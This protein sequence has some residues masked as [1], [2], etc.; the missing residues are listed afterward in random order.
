MLG[1]PRRFQI[2][3]VLISVAT[4]SCGGGGGGGGG[5]QHPPP[6][7][8]FTIGVSASPIDVSQGG[9]SRS[10]LLIADF[11][12]QNVYLIDPD[13][14]AYNGTSVKVG[15]VAGFLNSGPAR[16]T[17]T[18]A[19]T[20]FVGPQRGRELYRRVQQLPWPG[21]SP[22]QSSYL[23]ACSAARSHFAHGRTPPASRSCR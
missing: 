5:I 8:D 10:Q 11:G 3:L 21:E 13:G 18:S 6:Q 7:P 4:A 15:G 2:F 20:V 9:T 23:R 17:A 12:A 1:D 16:V 19:Q 14:A 22:S